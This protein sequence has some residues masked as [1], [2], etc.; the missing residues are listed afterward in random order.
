[1]PLLSF[2][3]LVGCCSPEQGLENVHEDADGGLVTLLRSEKFFA[4][5]LELRGHELA[6]S[7]ERSGCGRRWNQWLR[8]VVPVGINFWILDSISIFV[9]TKRAKDDV[10]DT[11]KI[12]PKM[13]KKRCAEP[14]G[15]KSGET[16]R[17]RRAAGEEMGSKRAFFSFEKSNAALVVQGKFTGADA[18]GLVGAVFRELVRNCMM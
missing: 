12:S 18:E 6:C 3:R 13:E 15:T 16:D 5:P 2:E 1:M 8:E 10:R 4:H 11:P 9:S 7:R 17:G 14:V